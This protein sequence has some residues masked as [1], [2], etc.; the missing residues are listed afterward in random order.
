MELWDG[1]DGLRGLH[2]H[3]VYA[4]VTRVFLRRFGFR[5]LGFR[6]FVYGERCSGDSA[7]SGCRGVQGGVS[8]ERGISLEG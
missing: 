6:V 7:S 5:V 8:S 3:D 1:E 2:S 4:N